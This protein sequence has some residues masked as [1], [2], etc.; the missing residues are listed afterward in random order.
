MTSKAEIEFPFRARGPWIIQ[1]FLSHSCMFIVI[2]LIHECR[3]L[4]VHLSCTRINLHVIFLK[5]RMRD[6]WFGDLELNVFS[7]AMIILL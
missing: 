3:T 6:A 2:K 4:S 5:L 7:D 1:V